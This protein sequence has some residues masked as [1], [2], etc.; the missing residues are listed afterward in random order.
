MGLFDSKSTTNITN[1]TSNF[2]TSQ[3]GAQLAI[4]AQSYKGASYAIHAPVEIGIGDAAIRS[5]AQSQSQL[6]PAGLKGSVA[7]LLGLDNPYIVFA[8]I[9]AIVLIFVMRK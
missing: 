3:D 6:S 4:S 1:E 9:G 5:F 2:A 8:A 7:Q